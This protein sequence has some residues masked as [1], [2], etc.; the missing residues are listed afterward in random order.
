MSFAAIANLV[1]FVL[2]AGVLFNFRKPRLTLGRQ[3]LLGLLLGAGYGLALQFLYGSGDAAV[4][5]TLT[6]TNVVATGYI[7]LLKMV[8]MPLVLVMM[9]AAVVRMREVADLGRIGGSVVGILVGTTAVAALVGIFV[10]NLF[11]LSADAITQGAR[12]LERAASLTSRYE[13]VANLGLP[14]RP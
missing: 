13:N 11:G 9:I 12:E 14:L 6:W 2:L 8:I 7:S 10:S 4:K 1:V 3:I 5:E